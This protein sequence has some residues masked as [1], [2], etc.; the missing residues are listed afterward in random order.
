MPCGPKSCAPIVIKTTSPCGPP[1][2]VQVQVPSQTVQCE[3]PPCPRPPNTTC[4]S[5][6]LIIQNTEERCGKRASG[7]CCPKPAAPCCPPQNSCGGG[8]GGCQTSCS[9]P[10][11]CMPPMNFC[12]S[13]KEKDKG[14]CCPN[15]CPPRVRRE[16]RW[17]MCNFMKPCIDTR[18]YRD[19]EAMVIS[20]AGHIPGEQYIHG[21]NLPTTTTFAKRRLCQYTPYEFIDPDGCCSFP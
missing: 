4:L 3:V 12:S 11:C 18:I 14:G 13:N 2:C 20:Y 9:R 5:I 6:P 10:A 16:K 15:G 7:G 8:G 17:P 21:R 1:R 19:G